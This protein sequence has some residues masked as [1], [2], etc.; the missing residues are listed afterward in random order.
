[1]NAPTGRAPRRLLAQ[2]VRAPGP[3]PR[4]RCRNRRLVRRAGS[5]TR[6]RQFQRLWRVEHGADRATG[7]WLDAG[8]G[9]GT[10]TR[11]LVAEGLRVTAVDYSELTTHKARQRSPGDVDWAVADATCLPFASASVD[12]A[13]CFGVMQALSSPHRALAEL[14]RVLRPGATLWVDALNGRCLPNAA[15]AAWRRGRGR[16]Q[17]LRYDAVPEFVDALRSSGFGDVHLHWLPVM[18]ERL[19]F[20]QP[21]AESAAA[22]TPAAGA[23]ARNVGQPLLPRGGARPEGCRES[24]LDSLLRLGASAVA[25]GG[26]R[27]RLSILMYHRVLPAPDPLTGDIDAATF[28]VHMRALREYFNVLPLDEAVDRLA[29]GRLPGACR[30]RHVRRRLRGQ[31]ARGAADPAGSTACTRRSSSPTASSTAAACSTTP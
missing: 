4:R 7:H 16:P 5:P 24:P 1:M 22:R 8:C 12:G 10:Y 30:G 28:D 31:P 21:L 23:A 26:A 3:D 13:L 14:R 27:A 6:F 15:A 20:L 11:F 25:P 29:D 19:R 18:P 2:A 17:H 9:A